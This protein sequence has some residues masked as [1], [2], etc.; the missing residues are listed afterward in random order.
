MTSSASASAAS[1]AASVYLSTLTP[2]QEQGI[3]DL[4]AGPQQISG[5]VYQNSIGFTVE[6][7]ASNSP[8]LVYD[9]SGYSVLDSPLSPGSLIADAASDI[10]QGRAFTQSRQSVAS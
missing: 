3:T 9:V 2:L 10:G 4:S 6:P 1:S 5:Q 8:Y 7:N